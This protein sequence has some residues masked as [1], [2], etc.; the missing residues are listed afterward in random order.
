ME[1]FGMGLVEILIVLIVGLIVLGPGKMPRLARNL[2][3][4]IANFKKA[5]AE[6]TAE[7]TK[8]SEDTEKEDKKPSN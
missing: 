6:L 3:K 5:T 4:A 8:E 1:F 2:G 7:V